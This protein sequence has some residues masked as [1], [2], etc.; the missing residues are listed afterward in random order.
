MQKTTIEPQYSSF[1]QK[2]TT[3]K[4]NQY[5]KKT[6]TSKIEKIGHNAKAIG[7][8]KWSGWLKN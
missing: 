3:P 4:N 2:K 7:F 6:N 1:V 5:K 8:A